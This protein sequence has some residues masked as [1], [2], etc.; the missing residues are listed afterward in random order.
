MSPHRQRPNRGLDRPYPSIEV[1][2]ARFQL[3]IVN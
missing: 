3:L 2:Q 1:C